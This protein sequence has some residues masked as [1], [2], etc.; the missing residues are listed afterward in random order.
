M[1]SFTLFLQIMKKKIIISSWK[2]EDKFDKSAS[3][4]IYFHIT[5]KEKMNIF[6]P[7]NEKCPW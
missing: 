1:E 5:N 7:F 6:S 2:A 3:S 4:I